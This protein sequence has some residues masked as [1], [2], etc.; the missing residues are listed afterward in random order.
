MRYAFPLLFLSFLLLPG[1]SLCF[2]QTQKTALYVGSDACKECH[3]QEYN[4]FVKYAKKSK[5]F[6]SGT[7]PSPTEPG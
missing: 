4:S 3:E 7:A 1:M 5:S 2:A 6:N